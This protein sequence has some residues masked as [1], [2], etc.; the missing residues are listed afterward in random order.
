MMVECVCWMSQ[1]LLSFASVELCNF[2]LVSFTVRCI[3]DTL[4]W[5]QTGFINEEGNER[6]VIVLI[7]FWLSVCFSC[8]FWIVK[9]NYFAQTN[10]INGASLLA[11][12]DLLFSGH[13]LQSGLLG[14]AARVAW[15]SCLL[16]DTAEEHRSR[17]VI[18][19]RCTSSCWY[20][21]MA[22]PCS[23]V[24]CGNASVTPEN[25]KWTLARL[26]L[27]RPVSRAVLPVLLR[28]HWQSDHLHPGGYS[29]WCDRDTTIIWRSVNTK[30]NTP[31]NTCCVY[32]DV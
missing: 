15:T 1:S 31:V 3:K 14:V 13:G 25:T 12:S 30:L 22:L 6:S 16:T 17:F 4:I 11:F 2:S 19:T 27:H 24:W 5:Y 10:L 20:F 9:G 26:D 29:V 7:T 28:H 21:S 32:G 18:L 8:C 23:H